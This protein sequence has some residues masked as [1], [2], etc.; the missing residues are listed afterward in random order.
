MQK[1]FAQFPHK[2]AIFQAEAVLF[3]SAKGNNQF[4]KMPYKVPRDKICKIVDGIY[5]SSGVAKDVAAAS[6]LPEPKESESLCASYKKV[7]GV[8]GKALKNTETQNNFRDY[9]P[10]ISIS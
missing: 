1:K 5:V 10:F 9:I 8:I 2:H 3:H 6:N 4:V 7:L